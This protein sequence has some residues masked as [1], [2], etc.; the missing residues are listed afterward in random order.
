LRRSPDYALAAGEKPGT[1]KSFTQTMRDRY[2][3][4]PVLHTPGNHPKRGF[5]GVEVRPVDTSNQ[6]QNRGDG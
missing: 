4:E 3:F 5:L 1:K 2:G 6:W